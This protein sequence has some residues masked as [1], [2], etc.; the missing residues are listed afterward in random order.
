MGDETRLLI[1]GAGYQVEWHGYP[2]P[3]SLCA[4]EVADLRGFLRKVLQR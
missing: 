1:E 2:M 4:E 3:H